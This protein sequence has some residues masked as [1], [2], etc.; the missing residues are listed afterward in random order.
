MKKIDLKEML[1]CGVHFGHKV[2]HW[3][4][5]MAKFIF[6]KRGG[7]HVFDLNKTAKSLQQA[8]EFLARETASG[9]TVLL[10]STK[11][12]TKI[13]LEEFA[14]SSGVPVVTERWI[15]GMLTNFPTMLSRIRRLK[16]LN[17]MFASGEIEKFTKKEIAGLKKEQDKLQSAFGGILKMHKVPDILFV[18][19]A[20]RDETALKEARRLGITTVGLCDSNADPDLL[21]WPIPGNDDA[22][23]ALKFFLNDFIFPAVG[24]KSKVKG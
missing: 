15:G 8:C 11:P 3:N 17:E 5:K 20:K 19:D 22:I 23:S 4:P 6:G 24:K 18:V 21:D 7:V 12:Q 1:E 14:K 16:N 10:V 13:G 9:K 2:S